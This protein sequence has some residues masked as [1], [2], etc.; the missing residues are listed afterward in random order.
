MDDNSTVRVRFAPSPTGAPHIGNIRTALFNW[1]Y[2]RH[3]GGKFIVRIEDTDQARMVPGSQQAILDSLTWLGIDWDEGPEVGGPL[4]PYLQ[5]E[6][7]DLYRGHIERLL[8]A[9]KAYRCYCTPERLRQ[10]RQEQRSLKQPPRYDRK[11][12]FLLE[13]ER[14]ANE[15]IGLSSVVRF[16]TPTDGSTTFVDRLRG[17]ITFEHAVLD[18]HVLLK[19]D[20]WPTYQSANVID[21]HE[22]RI[23]HVIRGEDWISSAPKHILLYQAFGW[24]P[25]VMVHTP[26]IVGRDRSKLSKRHGAVD[27]LHYRDAGYLPEAMINYMALLGW[28]LDEKTELFNVDRLV[29]DFDLDRIGRNPGLFD[30]EKL[31]WMNGYYIR[32][33]QP[34]ELADRLFPFFDRSGLVQLAGGE[35]KARPIVEAITPHIQERM[36]RL[37]DAVPLTGFLFREHIDYDPAQLVPKRWDKGTSKLALETALSEI[38]TTTELDAE[39]MEARFRDIAAENGW[40]V[41]GFFGALRVAITGQAVAPPLFATMEVLGRRSTLD[42]LARAIRLLDSGD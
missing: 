34:L 29:R 40:K 22:M 9:G 15:A 26:N 23:S 13:C 32:Q 41:G 6:R 19:S 2:A 33:F 30:T 1:L 37:T 27:A 31:D 24:E 35:S 12:R 36:K 20:G 16:A 17:E 25:P 39:S 3:E 18:D 8:Q 38:E 10:M 14:A 11:C 21:D 7:L 5:S 28:A 4:G 42:R